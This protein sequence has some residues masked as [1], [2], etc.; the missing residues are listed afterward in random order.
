[1]IFQQSIRGL[2]VGFRHKLNP[3]TTLFP[4]MKLWLRPDELT[5]AGVLASWLDKSGQANNA[6]QA[7]EGSKPTVVLN[8]LNGHSIVNFDGATDYMDTASINLNAST[9]FM[10]IR[11]KASSVG[12]TI[13]GATSPGPEWKLGTNLIPSIDLS[14]VGILI[15]GTTSLVA[16]QWTLLTF[17]K[18]GVINTNA[19]YING[20]ADTMTSNA[21]GTIGA[22]THRIGGTH[23]NPTVPSSDSIYDGGIAELFVT[24]TA[25]SDSDRQIIEGNLA[26][27][28]RLEANLPVTHPYKTFDP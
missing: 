26:W 5:T 12:K 4:S 17:K 23:N 7:T 11:P 3:N 22:Y 20:T 15:S 25:L 8:S 28:Y 21:A 18:T 27:K 14:G 24:N 13:L 19:I 2:G 10:V 16:D 6:T 1:M 9:V